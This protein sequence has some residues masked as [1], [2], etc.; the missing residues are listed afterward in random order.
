MKP[1]RVHEEVERHRELVLLACRS[2]DRSEPPGRASGCVSIRS[3]E[4][5][6][7][8]TGEED[9]E[10]PRTDRNAVLIDPEEGLPLLGELAWPPP[11]TPAHLAIH[12]QLPGGG[13]VIHTREPATVALTEAVGAAPSA[14]ATV[15][16]VA[17]GRR[18]ASEREDVADLARLID[19]SGPVTAVLLAGSA[20][21][22]WGR[23]PEEALSGLERIR[24]FGRALRPAPAAGPEEAE[25]KTW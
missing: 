23:S 25:G 21:F 13:A 8:S 16:T 24:E 11:E 20:V 6:V 9:G 19:L 12:R 1:V 18:S 3:G 7:I 10:S 15:L 5:V 2:L 4:A 14:G 22:T 17:P